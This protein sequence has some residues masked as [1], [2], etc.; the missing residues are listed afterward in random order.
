LISSILKRAPVQ[1]MRSYLYTETDE[2][3]A[4]YF[5]NHQL[6]VFCSKQ[7]MIA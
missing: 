1:Y 3:D 2:S 6:D 7:S 5:V 4:A